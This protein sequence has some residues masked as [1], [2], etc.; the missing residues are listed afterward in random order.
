M[1]DVGFALFFCLAHIPAPEY[2]AL[3]T[4]EK[5]REIKFD[6]DTASVNKLKAPG[7]WA[8]RN[9]SMGAKKRK[10]AIMF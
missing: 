10:C 5:P 8:Q 9:W 6:Y 1:H 7:L 2:A 4:E 3:V